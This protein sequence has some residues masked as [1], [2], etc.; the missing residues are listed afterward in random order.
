MTTPEPQASP[1]GECVPIEALQL[2]A[3]LRQCVEL[4]L[5]GIQTAAPGLELA[6]RYCRA[7]G[8]AEGLE[9]AA[10]LDERQ[11]HCLHRHFIRAQNQ[12]VTLI[13]AQRDASQPL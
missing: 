6:E 2:S 7:K 1:F 8:F 4:M 3:Y 10:A 13:N 5:R 9:A 12:R 11:A